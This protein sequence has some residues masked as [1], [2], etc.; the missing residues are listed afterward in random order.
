MRVFSNYRTGDG[1]ST[2]ALIEQFLAVRL[3]AEN[4][5]RDSKSIEPGEIFDHVLLRNVWRSDVLVAVMG[6][7][8]LGARDEQGRALDNEKDWVRREIVE[9]FAH[10]VRVIPVLIGDAKHPKDADL[11]EPLSRLAHCQSV[12]LNFRTP[13]SGLGRLA[14]AVDAPAGESKAKRAGQRGGIGSIKGGTVYAVTDARGPVHIGDNT[15]PRDER[16]DDQ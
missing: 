14:A 3:G 15:Y 13:D 8:W 6:V 2:A 4:V 16:Q 10:G 9:A 12:T 7:G 11:P 1:E 5:F